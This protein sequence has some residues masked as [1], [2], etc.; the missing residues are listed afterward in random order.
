[1]KFVSSDSNE[2][3]DVDETSCI[4]TTNKCG[5]CPLLTESSLLRTMD[6]I[7]A[8]VKSKD[9][10]VSSDEPK[11]ANNANNETDDNNCLFVIDRIGH[12]EEEPEN[13]STTH[14][15]GQTDSDDK[16][17]SHNMS[18]EQVYNQEQRSREEKQ[19]QKKSNTPKEQFEFVVDVDG[20]AELGGDL[21]DLPT[22]EE[23]SSE[24]AKLLNETDDKPNRKSHDKFVNIDDDSSQDSEVILID[25][26][27]SADKLESFY[28]RQPQKSIQSTVQLQPKAAGFASSPSSSN[29]EQNEVISVG[30]SNSDSDYAN[31][32][33]SRREVLELSLTSNVNTNSTE[34]CKSIVKP[35]FGPTGKIRAR[36]VSVLHGLT[37][38]LRRSSFINTVGCRSKARVPIINC[39]T[40]TGFEG[41]I[42]IGGHNGVDTS[43]YA[44]SQA[45]RFQ[46]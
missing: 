30:D 8:S 45:N 16:D 4:L 5:E 37:S 34:A 27:D 35:V 40:R 12:Q 36:V 10:N 13:N 9:N 31:H 21:E 15:D 46:R 29:H 33:N 7:Q 22:N 18:T 43:T 41:D 32:Q 42:A 26:N 38:H 25:D 28:S 2:T 24:P 17:Q 3:E 1:M 39:N 6:A 19:K 20:V 14:S 11:D 44:Q 23:L